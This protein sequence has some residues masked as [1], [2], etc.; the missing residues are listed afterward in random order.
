MGDA[1]LDYIR[2]PKPMM[3][4][5]VEGKV[6]DAEYIKDGDK[7]QHQI[8]LE[9]VDDVVSPEEDGMYVRKNGKWYKL[10]IDYNE[11]TETLVIDSRQPIDESNNNE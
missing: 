8:N 9:K 2:I 6:T 10:L 3:P 4:A 5:E 7:T 11:E 1:N